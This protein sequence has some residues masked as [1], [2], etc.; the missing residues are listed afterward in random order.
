MSVMQRALALIYPDQC[1]LCGELV[2]RPGAL[3]AACWRDTDFLT[4]H[5]CDHCAIPL[6]GS[7]DGNADLCD[8]C[9]S[10]ERPWLKGRAVFSYSGAGRRLVLGLKHADRTD[11]AKPSAMW[12]ARAG[13]ELLADGTVIVPVP[14]HWRR[15]VQRR[16]NQAAELARELSKTTGLQF[17]PDA[18]VRTRKTRIQD[19]MTIEQRFANVKGAITFNPRRKSD[20]QGCSV[21]VIDDVMTSGATLSAATEALYDAG[22]D[23]VFV[24]ALARVIKTP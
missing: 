21:C 5:C 3:C 7:G 11:L 15:L 24:L 2:E 19:G 9:L 18:L 17:C 16:Y 1:I 12:M 6:A 4:G 8:D 14:T 23:Q 13:H 20:I 10:F 22:A